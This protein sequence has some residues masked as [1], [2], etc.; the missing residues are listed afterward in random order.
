MEITN[1]MLL[2]MECVAG[3]YRGKYI[4]KSQKSLL[5]EIFQERSEESFNKGMKELGRIQN[6]EK[7][8]SATYL[9]E[10]LITTVGSQRT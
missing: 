10:S 3:L 8:S 2:A 4:T 7:N 9:I 5:L 6:S 1:K